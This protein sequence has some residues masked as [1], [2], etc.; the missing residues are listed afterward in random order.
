MALSDGQVGSMQEQHI[1]ISKYFG[2][3]LTHHLL[4]YKPNPKLLPQRDLN[5][6]QQNTKLAQVDPRC[7]AGLPVVVWVLAV[8]ATC[9]CLVR[10]IRYNVNSLPKLISK[11][12]AN[13]KVVQLFGGTDFQALYLSSYF[14]PK[15]LFFFWILL[16][17]TCACQIFVNLDDSIR[18]GMETL[19]SNYPAWETPGWL[20]AIDFC[21][22]SFHLLTCPQ[23][24][25]PLASRSP[26]TWLAKGS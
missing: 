14:N 17:N 5:R 16:L 13:K 23:Q 21:L 2:S 8:A 20:H 24:L 22:G 15:K 4:I 3:R 18:F 1:W 11:V 6:S 19:F 12:V 10:G 7:D 25:A 9:W 26:K